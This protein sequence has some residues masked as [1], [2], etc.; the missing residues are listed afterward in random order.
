MTTTPKFN[1]DPEVE[2]STVNV[3]TEPPWNT[4]K[5]AP[6]LPHVQGESKAIS[7]AGYAAQDYHDQDWHCRSY[8]NEQVAP[9]SDRSAK[10]CTSY[11]MVVGVMVP[12]DREE[13]SSC[14]NDS[15]LGESISPGLSSCT[16]DNLFQVL[17]NSEPEEGLDMIEPDST[18][19]LL[20][21]PVSRSDDG[22]LKF[23][24]SAF[25][26][27]ASSETHGS[28]IMPLVARSTPAGER[29]L[30]MTDLVSVDESNWTDNGSS[31]D[32]RKTYLPNG[33]PPSCS[34]LPSTGT[35]SK[36]LLSDCI[37]NY[38]ENW[39][40]GCL[41]DPSPNDRN[42]SVSGNR[43]HELSEPEE[44]VDD[45]PSELETIFLSGWMVQI[46]G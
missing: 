14:A 13:L 16:E 15:G 7:N 2:I 20:V 31:S 24:M 5:S 1:P 12:H 4:I 6:G 26:P 40:P 18:S 21:L 28:E 35:V 45:S 37:S 46:Q 29:T 8:R 25:Q 39:V 3:Y 43:L 44:D 30:L 36:I 41:Q 33:V 32:Y 11:S 34:E 10:S 42:C 38:R 22:K 27:V 9:I 19:E 17:S 23:S